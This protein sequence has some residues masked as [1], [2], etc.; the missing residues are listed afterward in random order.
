MPNDFKRKRGGL[1]GV[2]D[3]AAAHLRSSDTT[4]DFKE[5]AVQIA[6]AKSELKHLE[7]NFQ[8]LENICREGSREMSPEQA[9]QQRQ[10]KQ[11]FD[12]ELRRTDNW[13]ISLVETEL[14]IIEIIHPSHNPLKKTVILDNLR[15]AFARSLW[16]LT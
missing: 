4:A 6:E 16:G 5:L 15:K 2:V 7:R 3:F 12:N 8:S 14:S 13:L 11:R 9:E 1:A 10:L